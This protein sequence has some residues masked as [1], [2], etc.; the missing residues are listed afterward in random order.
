MNRKKK[1]LIGSV[2]A[3]VVLLA[4]GIPL[5]LLYGF[6]QLVNG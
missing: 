1:M 4:I 6:Q 2:I 3:A 5:F